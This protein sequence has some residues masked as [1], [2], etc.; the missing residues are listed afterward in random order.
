MTIEVAGAVIVRDNLIF[1]AQRPLNK[2]LGGF[3]E[4]PGGKLEEAENPREALKREIVE[5]L[6][7]E[8]VV[9]DFIVRSVHSYDFGKVALSTFYCTLVDEEPILKEHSAM[10]WLSVEEL[11]SLE[12]APADEETLNIIKNTD[13]SKWGVYK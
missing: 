12:W 8:V 7:C 10:K 5:E 2:S 3:W 9:H 6:G 13:I 4:F 1:A 11:D